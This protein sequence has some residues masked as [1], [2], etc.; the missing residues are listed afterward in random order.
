MADLSNVPSATRKT[1]PRKSGSEIGAVRRRRKSG[2]APPPLEEELRQPMV[3]PKLR[4]ESSVKRAEGE[5]G[6]GCKNNGTGTIQTPWSTSTSQQSPN[7]QR[8]LACDSARKKRTR[9]KTCVFGDMVTGSPL[10]SVLDGA[11]NSP[12]EQSRKD[13]RKSIGG[14]QSQAQ[15]KQG[16]RKSMAALPSADMTHAEILRMTSELG[17]LADNLLP[18]SESVEQK[19]HPK[20]DALGGR[21]LHDALKESWK[22]KSYYERLQEMVGETPQKGKEMQC[23]TA[24]TER[25][26]AAGNNAYSSKENDAQDNEVDAT[27]S[28][29]ARDIASVLSRIHNGASR[30]DARSHR[31]SEKPTPQ[32][33]AQHTKPQTSAAEEERIATAQR[34]AAMQQAAA[35]RR[36]QE[37]AKWKAAV[38]AR[39][40]AEEEERRKKAEQ[41]QEEMMARKEAMQIVEVDKVQ[42]NAEQDSSPEQETTT[43]DDTKELENARSEFEAKLQIQEAAARDQSLEM[44]RMRSEL[45]ERNREL[46][47]TRRALKRSEAERDSHRTHASKEIAKAEFTIKELREQVADLTEQKAEWEKRTKEEA[48]AL[49]QR[50]QY[51]VKAAEQ[52]VV[53]L[54]E[55]LQALHQELTGL[56]DDMLT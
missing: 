11:I 24:K 32:S 20:D 34:V 26:N 19:K 52:R 36:A 14:N 23:K 29:S 33:H 38:E 39:K 56:H 2:W 30:T 12:K 48:V 21:S 25:S 37:E 40:R 22:G 4:S 55:Q 49:S 8:R 18:G 9:R 42:A 10:E 7:T 47:D 54:S 53:M 5:E 35:E 51:R 50:A 41:E 46:E 13:R 28:I 1:E 6:D 44:E 27:L 45:A 16:R 15:H 43:V 31:P 17:Q 3:V